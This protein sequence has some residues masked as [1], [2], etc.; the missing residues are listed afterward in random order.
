MIEEAILGH[1]PLKSTSK[2][3][4]NICK[5]CSLGEVGTAERAGVP[6]EQGAEDHKARDGAV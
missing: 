2:F 5:R 4:L 1:D 6:R 3:S